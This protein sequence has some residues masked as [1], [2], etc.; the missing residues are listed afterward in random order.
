MTRGGRPSVSSLT[1]RT[2]GTETHNTHHNYSIVRCWTSSATV[3]SSVEHHRPQHQ[4]HLVPSAT[5]P[6]SL[7]PIGHS[8][9]IT[10]SHRP[11]LQHL[12]VPSATALASTNPDHHGFAISTLPSSQIYQNPVIRQL[13]VSLPSTIEYNSNSQNDDLIQPRSDCRPHRLVLI[14]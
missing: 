10:W 11:Q 13:R 5:A 12:L 1:R 3:L 7:G 9:S 8:F 14:R 6:A 2:E 4:H